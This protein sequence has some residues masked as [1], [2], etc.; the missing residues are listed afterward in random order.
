MGYGGFL[1][2]PPV[3]GLLA[4]SITLRGALGIVALAL[5]GHRIPCSSS[6]S[7][8]NGRTLRMKN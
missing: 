3:I 4:E 5:T 6:G 8:L 7:V 2:G 1:I